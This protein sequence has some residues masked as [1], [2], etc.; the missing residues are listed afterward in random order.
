MRGSRRFAA[1]AEPLC[2]EKRL[3]FCGDTRKFNNLGGK[4]FAGL[5]GLLAEN[6]LS[7]K[8]MESAQAAGMLPSCGLRQ[9]A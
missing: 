1:A 5:Y 8:D 2:T 6:I 9:E 7:Y 3:F 4:K